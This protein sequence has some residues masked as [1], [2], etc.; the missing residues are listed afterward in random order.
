MAPDELAMYKAQTEAVLNE[1]QHWKEALTEEFGNYQTQVMPTGRVLLMPEGEPD[2]N[3]WLC[4]YLSDVTPF[5]RLVIDDYCPELADD[6]DPTPIPSEAA[7][8]D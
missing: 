4:C 1:I 3:G 5:A 7:S 8:V 2:P 6:V